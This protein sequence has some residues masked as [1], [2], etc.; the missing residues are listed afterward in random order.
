MLLVRPTLFVLGLTLISLLLVGGGSGGAPLWVALS[1]QAAGFFAAGV[2]SE[3][4][5]WIVAG[6]V[7]LPAL[8]ADISGAETG[9]GEGPPLAFLELLFLPGFLAMFL[10]GQLVRR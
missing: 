6:L 4:S 8:L 9:Q 10:V 7:F 1:C 3:R 5:P 2:T